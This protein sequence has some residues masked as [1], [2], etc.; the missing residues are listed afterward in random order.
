M[1]TISC[2]A[3][4]LLPFIVIIVFPFPCIILVHVEFHY[5]LGDT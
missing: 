1:Y 5:T 3:F 4:V 2:R